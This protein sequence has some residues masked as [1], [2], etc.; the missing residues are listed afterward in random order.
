MKIFILDH[1]IKAGGNLG[2]PFLIK[3]LFKGLAQKGY[4]PTL[5]TCKENAAYYQTSMGN[6]WP[7]VMAVITRMGQR[8]F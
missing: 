6:G 7:H 2:V 1:Q 5:I 4:E 8:N 3:V